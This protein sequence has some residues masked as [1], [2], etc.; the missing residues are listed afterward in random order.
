L[1]AAM[2]RDAAC[3]AAEKTPDAG[4][5]S[6]KRRFARKRV[7]KDVKLQARLKK[8]KRERPQERKQDR[9][10]SLAQRAKPAA[11][12]NRGRSPPDEDDGAEDDDAERRPLNLKSVPRSPPAPKLQKAARARVRSPAVAKDAGAK[13]A[14]PAARASTGRGARANPSASSGD[15]APEEVPRIPRSVSVSPPLEPAGGPPSRKEMSSRKQ[16]PIQLDLRPPPPA[17]PAKSRGGGSQRRLAQPEA[18]SASQ[19]SESRPAPPNHPPPTNLI[20]SAASWKEKQLGTRVDKALEEIFMMGDDRDRQ[21]IEQLAEWFFLKSQSAEQSVLNRC[22]WLGGPSGFP[23]VAESVEAR[24]HMQINDF[25]KIHQGEVR[26][27]PTS[28]HDKWRVM[29]FGPHCVELRTITAGQFCRSTKI[30]ITIQE[31]MIAYGAKKDLIFSSPRQLGRAIDCEP[32][33]NNAISTLAVWDLDD[34]QVC[35]R[36]HWGVTLAEVFDELGSTH[37]LWQTYLP[38]YN[39]WLKG[40]LLIRARPQLG[41][42]TGGKGKR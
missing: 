5:R 10:K 37:T 6:F 12:K 18:A 35:L 1:L 36:E 19:F 34:E 39:E 9:A 38:L 11:R 30:D 23:L 25:M 13:H 4:S 26:S 17:V 7:T 41:T 31:R 32:D 21:V 8:A 2:P 40:K 28:R 3:G 33:V 20:L 29:R 16:Q 24:A 14:Q 27:W 22:V 15:K 42:S